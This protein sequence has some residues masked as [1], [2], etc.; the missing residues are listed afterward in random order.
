M[1]SLDRKVIF[2]AERKDAEYVIKFYEPLYPNIRLY[3][4]ERFNGRFRNL[5]NS[6]THRPRAPI[7]DHAEA[8]AILHVLECMAIES[9]KIIQLS[10]DESRQFSKMGLVPDGVQLH[11]VRRPRPFKKP[12]AGA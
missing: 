8:G 6:Q 12:K 10:A 1:G 3:T 4:S 5:Y 11:V 9:N 2:M 7:R